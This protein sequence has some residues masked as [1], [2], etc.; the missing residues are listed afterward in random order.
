MTQ[1]KDTEAP[2]KAARPRV[3]VA[4]PA[5]N[6][7]DTI[8]TTIR[9][10]LRQTVADIE[11]IV[12]NDASTDRTSQILHSINDPRL[13]VLDNGTNLGGGASRDRAIAAA[14]GEWVAVLDADDVW[15]EHRLENMLEA[16]R[17]ETN[18][19]I[20]DDLLICHHTPSGLVPWRRMWGPGAFNGDGKAPVN[21]P[22][23]AWTGSYQFLIKPLIHTDTLHDSGVRHSQLKFGEDTEFFIRLLARGLRLRYVPCAHYLYRITPNSASANTQRTNLM[24]G[25]LESMLP[26]FEQHPDVQKAIRSRIQYRSLVQNIKTGRIHD[27]VKI[28]LRNPHALFELIHR[29]VRQAVYLAH[30]RFHSGS[31]R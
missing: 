18:V 26:L 31:S 17:G 9:S 11:V 28:V 16:T 25:M 14:R 3:S 21:V 29:V 24:N 10:A 23:A 15:E 7:A 8:E 1:G 6:A 30:R 4:I 12:C 27:A 5:Y 19:M 20:F 2:E 13:V 22:I